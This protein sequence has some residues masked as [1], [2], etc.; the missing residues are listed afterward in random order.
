MVLP[1]QVSELNLYS[2]RCRRS[3]C[4]SKNVHC[5]LLISGHKGSQN[6]YHGAVTRLIS[7]WL[8]S[9]LPKVLMLYI[10]KMLK[11]W[12]K[13]MP[14]LEIW[15]KESFD[16]ALPARPLMR[17]LCPGEQMARGMAPNQVWQV[18]V[19]SRSLSRQKYVHQSTESHSIYMDSC[20]GFWKLV[21]GLHTCWKHLLYCVSQIPSRLIT[22]LRILQQKC[23]PF[24]LLT[25]SHVSLEFLT[26][27]QDKHCLYFEGNAT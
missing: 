13:N 25:R 16:S 3:C 17:R 11:H 14:L 5:M 7:E 12:K 9:S 22:C 27:V 15:L 24:T 19:T 18:D 1:L 4:V 2:S 6:R 20:P 23:V 26:T 10:S 8:W 21:P